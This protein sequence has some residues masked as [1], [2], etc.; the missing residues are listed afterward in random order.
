MRW[1]NN[2]TVNNEARGSLGRLEAFTIPLQATCAICRGRNAVSRVCR[3]SRA[4]PW[5]SAWSSSIASTTRSAHEHAN[6]YKRC[7][8]GRMDR[9]S[10]T[11]FQR[12]KCTRA[13]AAST[14][15]FPSD[16]QRAVLR[17]PPNDKKVKEPP[18]TPPDWWAETPEAGPE[19]GS[20][21]RTSATGGPPADSV[22]ER[23]EHHRQQFLNITTSFR[24][25]VQHPWTLTQHLLN[26]FGPLVRISTQWQASAPKC[27][28]LSH[29]AWLRIAPACAAPH[30]TA[31]NATANLLWCEY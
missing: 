28:Y 29:G 24:N 6:R 17:V 18:G 7:F 27:E 12:V 11:A 3:L 14:R 31:P 13:Q 19:K 23:P 2:G 20:N 10:L 21:E 30:R 16:D 15:W 8:R 26:I 4:H 1:W 5:W 9:C 22:P 25:H